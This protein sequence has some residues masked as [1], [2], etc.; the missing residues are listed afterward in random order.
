MPEYADENIE[1][2]DEMIDEAN[3]KRNAGMDAVAEGMYIDLHA[4]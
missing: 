1:V 2:T 3:D 4:V